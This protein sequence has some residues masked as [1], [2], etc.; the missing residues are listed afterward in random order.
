MILEKQEKK[1][2]RKKLNVND[3]FVLMFFKTKIF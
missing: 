2:E 3:I 1:S